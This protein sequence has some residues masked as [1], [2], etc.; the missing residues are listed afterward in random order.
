MYVQIMVPVYLLSLRI[1]KDCQS[2]TLNVASRYTGCG[3]ELKVWYLRYSE[4]ETREDVARISL[5]SYNAN[6]T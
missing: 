6:T 2:Y 4:D 3:S 5:T 1:G